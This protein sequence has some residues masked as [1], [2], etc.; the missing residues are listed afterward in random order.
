M[1]LKS[2]PAEKKR[3]LFKYCW[4]ILFVYYKDTVLNLIDLNFWRVYIVI[5]KYLKNWEYLFKLSSYLCEIHRKSEFTLDV[6]GICQQV[7]KLGCW[8]HR[9]LITIETGD[10]N[11]NKTINGS[12]KLIATLEDTQ[13]IG[14]RFN[15]ITFY[16]YRANLNH[17]QIGF[18]S[19]CKRPMFNYFTNAKRWI[20]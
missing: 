15:V 5:E 12:N 17:N 9:A 11:N 19:E 10:S 18:S 2:K 6:G 1:K 4:Q 16:K 3:F 14:Y 7:W 20:V 8:E 13:R